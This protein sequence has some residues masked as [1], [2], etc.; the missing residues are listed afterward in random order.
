MFC[1]GSD[2][3]GCPC[4]KL[5][6]VDFI[7]ALYRIIDEILVNAVDNHHRKG[8]HTN[9]LRVTVD[10]NSN[11]IEVY[12]NGKSI[13][14]TIHPTEKIYV[15]ELVFG[16]LLT[17]SNF[18]DNEVKFTGGRNGYGAKLANIFS[19]DF[20]VE[21][22]D[23]KGSIYKQHWSKNMSTCST[24]EITKG[25]AGSKTEPY[26]KV[27]FHPDFSKFSSQGF[28]YESGFIDLIKRRI[29]DLSAC[30][31]KLQV[32][33]NDSKIE[34]GS[35]KEYVKLFYS[36]NKTVEHPE[37]LF[38]HKHIADGWEI[39]VG[40]AMGDEFSQFSFVNS[41]S[42]TQGGSHVNYVLFQLSSKISEY[43]SKTYSDLQLTIP[44]AMVKNH[45]TLFVNCL[46]ENPTFDSQ[47]KETLTTKSVSFS[48]KINISNDFIAQIASHTP[49]IE[50]I[51]S[52]AQ[53]KQSARAKKPRK[54]ESK[55]A[56]PKLDD[57][58]LAGTDRSLECVLIL[59][60]GDS[61][62][63]L[64]ISGL[65]VVER[66]RYG[67]FPLRGKVLNVREASMDQ[68]KEN[69]EVQHLKKILGLDDVLKTDSF[70]DVK[71]K[72]R[73][74]KIM[75][76][77]DQDHDGSH[78]KGLLINMI[79]YFYPQLLKNNFIDQFITPIVK[80]SKGAETKSF[81]SLPEF[82]NW[83]NSLSENE[84]E[85]W[86]QKYYK[87]LGTNTSK[88]AKEY[89]SNLKKH[90]IEMKYDEKTEE[91]IEKAF[92][93]ELTNV[94]KLWLAHFKEGTYLDTSKGT[95][96]LSD[97]I[98]KEL[99][100]FSNQ[101]NIRSIP[102]LVDGLKPSQRK[103]LFC[104]LKRDLKNEIKVAQLA[105]Y[106]SEHSAYHHGEQALYNTITGMAQDFVGSNNIPL[107]YPSGQF[108]T[109]LQG[110]DDAASA[111]YI[112]TR[113]NKLTRMIFMKED[114]PILDYNE[115]DNMIIE[116]KFY[117]PIIPMLLVNGAE[118]MGTGWSTSIPTFN[119]LDLIDALNILL[120]SPNVENAKIPS[121]KMWA[122]GF[123]GVIEQN[124]ND[125]FTVKGIYSVKQKGDV[126]EM[127][128]SELPIGEWTEHFKTHLLTLASK[129]VVKPK[130]SERNTESTVGFTL[131]I[132]S[133]EITPSLLK[134]LKLEKSF[135][136]TNMTVFS[137][138]Q[139]IVQY[140]NVEEIIKQFYKVRVE[141]Y[142]KRK[143]HQ[144]THLEK[145]CRIL[146]NK[147]KFL[148]Y[149]TSGD[150]NMKQFMK[151]KREDIPSFLKTVVGIDINQGE[152]IS[153]LTDMSLLSLTTENK[154][155]LVK[156][157][158]I[159]KSDL[160]SIKAD[161][162]KQMWKRDLKKLKEELISL[163]QQWVV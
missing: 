86:N 58:N 39:A 94:R 40:A 63:A 48:Q 91:N 150:S 104:C 49:I 38:V 75:L 16:Y 83:K 28:K 29:F 25:Q 13:P 64:A 89:F 42:T 15:P 6:E 114:D 154:E 43:I 11:W 76:M 36:A 82:E 61:A 47:T 34:V 87:G 59:T 137:A 97:F 110:G 67:V 81:F 37:K 8:T 9:E 117:V 152:S 44:P 2:E 52:F 145:Q 60:E 130:F 125:K 144:I 95:V 10:E 134:K 85:K 78:I 53:Y 120:D 93:K 92:S 128:I 119:P 133:S 132:N 90:I 88:E 20:I 21:I 62:K 143:V 162:A 46:I 100:L 115:E 17:G 68:I 116:P 22:R 57:A 135:A 70:E 151:T 148:D 33:L 98:D 129:D 107:L 3:E 131:T 50:N 105:G 106:V 66:D 7:P 163:K 45:L 31:P 109:R 5:Q 157:L 156:Q 77:C 23:A 122:R 127:D 1:L 103:I 160:N 30:N 158:E 14:I 55:L 18:D 139:E 96:T 4:V 51:I 112:F 161:T 35:F 149:I 102:S 99:I 126:I 118:G 74:G 121:L 19:T 73:Y 26:I 80:V 155:K 101:N 24:P 136:M 27:R 111:R 124:G 113:L 41:I 141:Y 138:N 146:T 69:Q 79:H 65:S 72:L 140:S 54:R 32:Y 71:K 147:V 123:K 153:Y 159:V 84:R 56:I 142:E 108:G 12:N